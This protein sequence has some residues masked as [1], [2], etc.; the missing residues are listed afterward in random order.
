M[1]VAKCH[2]DA[3]QTVSP[4]MISRP[5]P[6][7]PYS[8]TISLVKNNNSLGLQPMFVEGECGPNSLAKIRQ[9]YL[10]MIAILYGFFQGPNI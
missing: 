3:P 7:K 9:L 1:G 8:G 5:I 10:P 4:L 6:S 2:A